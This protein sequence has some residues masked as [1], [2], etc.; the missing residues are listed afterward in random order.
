MILKTI[1]VVILCILVVVQYVI[2]VR[3]SIKQGSGC[4]GVTLF[5]AY[6]IFLLVLF[7]LAGVF[8]F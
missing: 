7:W 4:F 3:S 8:D 1:A 6:T 5:T 2:G